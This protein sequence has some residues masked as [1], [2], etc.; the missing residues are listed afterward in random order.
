MAQQQPQPRRPP[1]PPGVPRLV[2]PLGYQ[3][4]DWGGRR[5]LK[6]DNCLFDT[7]SMPN[8]QKHQNLGCRPPDGEWDLPDDD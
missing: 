5:L 1:L 3:T 8:M 6:C 4:Q 2:P 7:F